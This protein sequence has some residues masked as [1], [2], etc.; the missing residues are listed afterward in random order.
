MSYDKAS[1][2][3]FCRCRRALAAGKVVK[4]CLHRKQVEHVSPA[5]P[6]LPAGPLQAIW[7]RIAP[8]ANKAQWMRINHNRHRS[9]CTS[10]L[11][12]NLIIHKACTCFSQSINLSNLIASTYPPCCSFFW[13]W[14]VKVTKI[15]TSDG[16]CGTDYWLIVQRLEA[17]LIQM[18]PGLLSEDEH[19]LKKMLCWV[20]CVLFCPPE[21]KI[22]WK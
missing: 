14:V 17:K 10:V 5:F 9:L 7:T 13:H 12:S 6:W 15:E 11:N 21:K 4:S 18:Q 3:A 1:Q 8:N 16:C 20:Y 22:I 19:T 2:L